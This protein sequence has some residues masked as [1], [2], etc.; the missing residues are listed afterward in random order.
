[1]KNETDLLTK[2]S[3]TSIYINCKI[4]L[5]KLSENEIGK[6]YI[7]SPSATSGLRYI[8]T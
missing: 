4:I 2:S 3:N 6:I 8:S 1:M 7:D 5:W